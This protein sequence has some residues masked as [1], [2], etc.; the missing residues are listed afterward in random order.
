MQKSEIR[1]IYRE[2]R[3]QLSFSQKEKMDDL[4]L[5][6]FQQLPISVPALIMTYA[7]IKKMGEFDPRLITDYCYFKNRDQKLLYSV[8]S[9]DKR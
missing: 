1:K 7:P 5:I 9:T 2:K 3:K 4:L 6:Q 8:M